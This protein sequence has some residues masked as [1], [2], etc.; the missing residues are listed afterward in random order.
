MA[1]ISDPS[2]NSDW[3]ADIWG[4]R[5]PFASGMAWRVRVDEFLAEAPQALLVT[6]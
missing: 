2:S 6:P 5:T 3:I 4:A 1:K